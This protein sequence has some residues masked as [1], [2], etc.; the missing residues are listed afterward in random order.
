M[1]HSGELSD[2]VVLLDEN[3]L[4]HGGQ[5]ITDQLL[6]PRKMLME[7]SS[8]SYLSRGTGIYGLKPIPQS[9]Q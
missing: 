7:D 5:M 9:T 4:G 2:E 3:L 1:G 6:D 8:D